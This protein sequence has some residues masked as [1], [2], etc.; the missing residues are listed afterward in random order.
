M[1]YPMF[2]PMPPQNMTG[3][4]NQFFFVPM[5]VNQNMQQNKERNNDSSKK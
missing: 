5:P 2:M 1:M 4:Q 3:Y